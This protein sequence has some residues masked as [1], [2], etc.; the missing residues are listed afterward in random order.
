[1][2]SGVLAAALL[3]SPTALHAQAAPERT[4]PPAAPQTPAF[5][6]PAPG[7]PR[8]AADGAQPAPA[9]GGMLT[10]IRIVSEGPHVRATPP[11]AWSPPAELGAS[12]RLEHSPGQDLDEAWPRPARGETRSASSGPATPTA[13]PST[14]SATACPR[15]PGGP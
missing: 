7:L 6:Q 4:G 11:R 14:M 9:A 12:L 13:S 10:Q 8:A 1:M 15:P 3:M 2:Q 5:A